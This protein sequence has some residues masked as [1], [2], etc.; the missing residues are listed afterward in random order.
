MCVFHREWRF[1]VVSLVL[2][3]LQMC[4]YHTR[5]LTCL[6]C[7]PWALVKQPTPCCPSSLGNVVTN[8]VF[9]LLTSR[10]CCR[11]WLALPC[12][13]LRSELRPLGRQDR[14][15]QPRGRRVHPC[16]QRLLAHVRDGKKGVDGRVAVLVCI[17]R[18]RICKRAAVLGGWMVV[19]R[20]ER[21]YLQQS[22]VFW[23]DELV[24]CRGPQLFTAA[25][26]GLFMYCL[27]VVAGVPRA[28][29][30]RQG[31]GGAPRPTPGRVRPPATRGEGPQ[32][33]SQGSTHPR[34]GD[35]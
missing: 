7:F 26:C 23:C 28:L 12:L 6:P 24:E 13:A 29:L 4:L 25:F 35:F 32:G 8:T 20:W 16:P 15:P 34:R 18:C 27:Q 1:V 33:P 17:N 22:K 9:L 21:G 5:R 2:L 30:H 14:S 11:R 10:K 3:P 19:S 31:H